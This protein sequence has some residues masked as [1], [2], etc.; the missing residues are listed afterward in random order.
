MPTRKDEAVCIRQWDWSETSQTVSL[1]GRESGVLR[2][3]AKG[4]KRERGPFSG[5]LEV[6]TRGEMIAISKAPPAMATLTAWDL[7]ETFGAVRQSLGAF[8]AGMYLVDLVHH[9]VTDADPHPALFDALVSA[10]RALGVGDAAPARRE[11][12]AVLRFEWATLSETGYRPEL[13]RDVAGGGG[14]LVDS[15]TY[16]FSPRLGGLTADTGLADVWR[17]R[18][19]TVRVLRAIDAGGEEAG[20]E[21]CGGLSAFP[22]GSVARASLLLAHYLREI[23]GREPPAM[24]AYHQSNLDR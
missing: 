19:E 23:L 6:L 15:P 2:A 16:A 9:A 17:V 18:S 5:G 10:L 21:G 7:R 24:R 12:E 22:T 3:V 13:H 14:G 4:A 8:R 11:S 20:P 1:F